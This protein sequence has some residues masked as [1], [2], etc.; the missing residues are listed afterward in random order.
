[1]RAGDADDE[2]AAGQ[3][4]GRRASGSAV[5]PSIGGARRRSPC[6]RSIPAG[7]P[8]AAP[9]LGR[10]R[11]PSAQV[12]GGVVP[13]RRSVIARDV[14]R[15][16]QRQVA[17][18]MCWRSCRSSTAC[19][20][21]AGSSSAPPAGRWRS[22]AALCRSCEDL[23]VHVA[24]VGQRADVQDPLAIRAALAGDLVP[25]LVQRRRL[26]L[27]PLDARCGCRPALPTP[28]GR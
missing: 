1:M 7:T 5:A 6:R 10:D 15:R 28:P 14:V 16:E 4:A 24:V 11:C 26:L 3:P 21:C 22:A 12:I 20:G 8:A 27:H 19:A 17:E 23:R 9:D 25:L 2:S 18:V 13:L